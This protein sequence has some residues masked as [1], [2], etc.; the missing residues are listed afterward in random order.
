MV[1]LTWSQFNNQIITY[2]EVK[3]SVEIPQFDSKQFLIL[4]SKSVLNGKLRKSSPGPNV[5]NIFFVA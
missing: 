4:H 3:H 2:A 5:I 1:T